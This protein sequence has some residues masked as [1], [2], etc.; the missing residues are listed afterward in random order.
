MQQFK[1]GIKAYIREAMVGTKR[2]LQEQYPDWR[3]RLGI[4]PLD[5][6]NINT[7]E[8]WDSIYA[9]EGGAEKNWRKYPEK[10]EYIAR[11]LLADT[12]PDAKVLELGCGVGIFA[13]QLKNLK[14][15][16]D[17]CGI[18]I[19]QVAIDEL[20]KNGL[21]GSVGN[22][23][24]IELPLEWIG[25]NVD[26][27][28]GLEFLE[29]LDDEP[30]AEVIKE[31]SKIIGNTGK[32]IF[33]SPDN[34]MGP[35]DVAE[36][37]VKFTKDT[38]YKFLRTAFKDVTVYQI[39]SRPSIASPGTYNFLVGVCSNRQKY[40]KGLEKEAKNDTTISQ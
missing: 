19:S 30:R 1:P 27:V 23:P 6:K 32:A 16:I 21:K 8:Y 9:T 7:K 4:H 25:S 20:Y 38:F 34:C 40:F 39:A 35:E 18:D 29:H 17:Y 5:F 22:L 14:P 10:F 31:V 15:S 13:A 36:H 37:R 24:G 26:V 3:E 12:A 11:N 28:V 33:S 2:Y